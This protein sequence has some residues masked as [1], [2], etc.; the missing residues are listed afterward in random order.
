[1]KAGQIWYLDFFAAI[2]VFIVLSGIFAQYIM[3]DMGGQESIPRLTSEAA[4]VSEALMGE[5]YPHNWT[6][7][8]VNQ[9]GITGGDW[10]VNQTKIEQMYSLSAREFRMG[11]GT[12]E[13]VYVEMYNGTDLVPF[14]G[15]NYA[16]DKP[17]T[18]AD[19]Q[20][21]IVRHLIYHGDIVQLQVIAW[22]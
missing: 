13:N 15:K 5:G 3:Q 6:A 12:S 2:I 17:S 21:A 14:S 8:T 10:R 11:L 7:A 9:I 1:M 18:Q 4:R 22:E 19:T 20:G 16:G